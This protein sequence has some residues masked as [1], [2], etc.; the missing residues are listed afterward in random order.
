[1]KG[2]IILLITAIA[3][4]GLT[5]AIYNSV[6]TEWTSNIQLSLA[7]VCLSELAIICTIGLL[8]VLNFKNGSTG[9]LIDG[10]ASLM[11][12]WSVIGCNLGGN[13]YSTGLLSISVIMLVVIGISVMGSHESDRRNDEIER[14][15]EQKRSFAT[16]RA[17]TVPSA[18]PVGASQ[19]NLTSMWQTIQLAVDDDDTQKRLRVLV[20]RI[21]ALPAN[22][23]PNQTIE[24][25]MTQI[26]AMCRALS[27]PEA[28][29]RVLVRINEKS[30]E[31]SNYIK[32]L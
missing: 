4:I 12:V 15:I 8:P 14:T 17:S 27:N 29:D 28:H 16:S 32:T 20:E 25:T 21:K 13:T 6:V 19:E 11:I 30:K 9:L 10:F 5:I 7:V 3:A 22:R 31:L 24:M 18:K 26:T 23:F 2:K 1:M